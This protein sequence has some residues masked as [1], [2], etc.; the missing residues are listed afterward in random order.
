LDRFSTNKGL[1]PIDYELHTLSREQKPK[2]SGAQF[3]KVDTREQHK[4]TPRF[5]MDL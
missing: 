1:N 2:G 5:K 3:A 4:L